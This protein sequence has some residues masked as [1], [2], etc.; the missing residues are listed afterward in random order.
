MDMTS[1]H[2]I[3]ETELGAKISQFITE[4]HGT[5]KYGQMPYTYHLFGVYHMAIML[6]GVD[7]VDTQMG[8]LTHDVIEDTKTTFEE[9]SEVTS[10]PTACNVGHVSK[11]PRGESPAETKSE[12]YIRVCST[13]ISWKIKCADVLFNLSHSKFSSVRRFE[14]YCKCIDI[15]I[16][17][18]DTV[19]YDTSRVKAMYHF[20]LG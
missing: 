3:F 12:Y 16:K 4:K 9:L 8:S 2:G 18:G 14:N 11:R 20:I 19:G 17:H 1:T 7:C 5:Q 15:L 10:V 13:F 6:F